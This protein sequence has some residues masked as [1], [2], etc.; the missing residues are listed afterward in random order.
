MVQLLL[1]TSHLR[2]AENLNLDNTSE[3]IEWTV[4]FVFPV[5]C[6]SK[7]VAILDVLATREWPYF[8]HLRVSGV[9]AVCQWQE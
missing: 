5:Q 7:C 2:T 4:N 9:K 1:E 6:S 8:Q 3:N